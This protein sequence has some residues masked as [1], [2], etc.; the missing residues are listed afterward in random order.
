MSILR[1][2]FASKI[3]ENSGQDILRHVRTFIFGGRKRGKRKN[4]KKKNRAQIIVVWN[5]KNRFPLSIFSLKS[6]DQ[7]I[8]QG[9]NFFYYILIIYN[10]SWKHHRA[11]NVPYPFLILETHHLQQRRCILKSGN[12]IG[13]WQ[14]YMLTIIYIKTSNTN[15]KGKKRQTIRINYIYGTL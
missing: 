4:I 10:N 9:M 8:A 5:E 1:K 7:N 3:I 11:P 6:S 13:L 2:P 14:K 15:E 12:S